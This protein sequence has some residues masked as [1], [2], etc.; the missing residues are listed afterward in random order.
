MVAYLAQ[1]A[2]ANVSRVLLHLCKYVI[3]S[4]HIILIIVSLLVSLSRVVF[5]V[6]EKYF[7]SYTFNAAG[8][9]EPDLLV[10][11]YR[12]LLCLVILP[13]SNMGL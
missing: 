3:Y 12:R 10:I 1:I 7:V 13:L 2:E 4:S 8:H 9:W 11:Q 6:A 5:D